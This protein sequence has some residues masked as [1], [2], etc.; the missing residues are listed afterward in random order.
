MQTG[1][2]NYGSSENFKKKIKLIRQNVNKIT[3]EAV[4]RATEIVYERIVH[5][6]TG[7][8]YGPSQDYR[9]P[10]TGKMP[11]PQISGGLSN[12]ILQKSITPTM[13]MIASLRKVANYN[14]YVHEGTK[15]MEPRPFIAE[16]V[17]K[18]EKTIY[19]LWEKSILDKAIRPAGRSRI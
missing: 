7:P 10:Q 14:I 12:S 16:A 6:V 2:K 19:E 5:N 13:R 8:H 1:R 4:D 3:P 11:I 18:H 9:G 15:Y 17:Q